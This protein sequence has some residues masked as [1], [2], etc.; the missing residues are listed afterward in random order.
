MVVL[1]ST[2]LTMAVIITN[3]ARYALTEWHWG[4]AN[5]GVLLALAGIIG[6]GLLG[7][8]E[9]VYEPLKAG[10]YGLHSILLCLVMMALLRIKTIV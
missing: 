8:A 6:E 1:L 9:R 2:W 10:F 4:V 7:S 5:A 3:T